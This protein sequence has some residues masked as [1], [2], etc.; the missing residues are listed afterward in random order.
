VYFAAGEPPQQERVDGAKGELARARSLA[1]AF[2]MVEEPGDLRG[3]EIGIEQQSRALRD[4]R[5]VAGLLQRRAGIGRAAILPHNRIVDRPATRA[6]PHH[7]GFALIGDPDRG[8]ITRGNA[9]VGQRGAHGCDHARP[10]LLR[11]VLD[12]TRRRIDLAKLLLCDGNRLKRAIEHDSASRGRALIDRE[13]KVGHELM[14]QILH[15]CIKSLVTASPPR[16]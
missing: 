12:M 14:L 7:R 1:R 5:L 3:R 15:Q 9:S 11:I 6:I 13:K 4:H 10:D 8:D 16:R 2:D